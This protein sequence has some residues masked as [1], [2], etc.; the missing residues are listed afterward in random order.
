MEFSKIDIQILLL[1]WCVGAALSAI[2]LIIPIY[3]IFFI[4][5]LVGWITVGVSSFLIFLH[6]KK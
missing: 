5:A 4:V 6:L 1:I 3:F 2:A